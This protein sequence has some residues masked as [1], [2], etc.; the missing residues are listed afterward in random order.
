MYDEKK[1][2]LGMSLSELQQVVAE[3]GMPKFTAGQIAK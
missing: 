3:L 2:L 1:V